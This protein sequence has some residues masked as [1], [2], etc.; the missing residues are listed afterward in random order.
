MHVLFD[1]EMMFYSFK[2]LPGKSIE[3]NGDLIDISENLHP[4]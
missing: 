3:S 1:F 2:L 4:V